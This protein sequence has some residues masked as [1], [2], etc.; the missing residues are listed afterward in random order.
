[1]IAVIESIY[2]YLF[3]SSEK[4]ANVEPS[5]FEDIRESWGWAESTHAQVEELMV[6]GTDVTMM[7]L[8]HVKTLADKLAQYL[9]HNELLF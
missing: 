5:E 3:R 6:Q 7:A 4:T 1:M 9:Q 2:L 8:P